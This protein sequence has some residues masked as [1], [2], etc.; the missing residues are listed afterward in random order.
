MSRKREISLVVMAVFSIT[1]TIGNFGNQAFGDLDRV[2][3]DY[4][5]SGCCP[6]EEPVREEGEGP[7]GDLDVD[8]A[9]DFLGYAY[10]FFDMYHD[11]D[12][13]DDLGAELQVWVNGLYD[14]Q[15]WIPENGSIPTHIELGEGLATND[16]VAHEYTHGVTLSIADFDVFGAGNLETKAICE[17]LSDMWAE[18]IDET[19]HRSTNDTDSVDD[20]SVKWIVGEDAPDGFQRSM[21]DPTIYDCVDRYSLYNSSN[22]IHENAGIGDKLG[23]LLTDGATFNGFTIEGLGVADED[24]NVLTASQLFYECLSYLPDDATYPDLYSGLVQAADALDV[25]NAEMANIQKACNAVEIATITEFGV[26]HFELDYYPLDSDAD[27]ILIDSGLEGEETQEVTV[28]S[29]YET[30][31]IEL[32]EDPSDSGIFYG[33]ITL[34]TDTAVAD[35]G[36]LQVSRSEDIEVDYVDADNGYTSGSSTISDTATIECFPDSHDDYD[37]WKAVGYP[38]CWCNP[39][40]CHGDAD[41]LIEGL[42]FIGET[43]VG[44]NDLE[45]LNAA[46]GVYEPPKG[47][48][49]ASIPNGICA[50]FDHAEEGLP[51]IGLSRVG[52]NDLSIFVANYKIYEAE[53]QGHGTPDD[54]LDGTCSETAAPS[55][56]ASPVPADEATGVSVNVDLEW[57]GNSDP[58]KYD[59]YFGTDST[60]DSDLIG[61]EYKGSQSGTGYDPGML[62]P[63]T[64]YY[65]QIDAYNCYGTKFGTVWSFTTA[66]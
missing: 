18:W 63:N 6:P 55:A 9:Y 57:T 60:P 45:I 33:T 41:G 34:N 23:Y 20:I 21:R 15:T 39:R 65:W 12:S 56:A 52:G 35:D 64:T 32:N 50:D 46:W 11:R 42:A 62:S 40:Q 26:V 4:D 1:T 47:P 7:T 13:Y 66:P 29:Q 53:T 25:T 19:Y 3:R 54:C 61:G 28:S 22:P 58:N 14:E 51:F 43:Y 16:I 30:E 8:L 27:I 37:E 44:G 2:I 5:G 49:I 17:S 36:E 38:D 31:T 48:G 59:V 24:P 10:D